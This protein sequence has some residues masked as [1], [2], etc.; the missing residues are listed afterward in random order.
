[1]TPRASTPAPRTSTRAARTGCCAGSTEPPGGGFGAGADHVGDDG[2][3]VGSYTGG[4]VHVFAGGASAASGSRSRRPPGASR[5]GT[6]F[7]AERR[8]RRRR[9]RPGPLRRRLHARAATAGPASTPAATARRSGPGPAAPATGADRAARR[10]TSTTT[11]AWTSPSA[12]TL[13]GAGRRLLRPHRPRPAHVHLD[14]AGRPARLRRARHRRRRPRRRAG[15]A[16][17]SRR[18]RHALPRRRAP[19][20]LGRSREGGQENRPLRT[21]FLATPLGRP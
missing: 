7:V 10:A 2:L 17:L 11:G 19:P 18:G 13:A 14:D 4:G 1:M 6:F 15:P 9:P 20:S 12:R 21:G 8:A 3:I 16:A 5:F